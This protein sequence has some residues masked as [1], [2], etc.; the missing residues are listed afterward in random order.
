MTNLS[1]AEI[2][3]VNNANISANFSKNP[4]REIL[5]NLTDEYSCKF[6]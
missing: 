5:L 4:K 1:E 2:K 3:I 6:N